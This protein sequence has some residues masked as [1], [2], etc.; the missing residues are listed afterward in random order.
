MFQQTN[1]GIC[2]KVKVI[3]KASRSELVGWEKDE[4][5]VRLAALPEK[6]EANAELIRYLAHLLKL[7][8]SNIQLVQGETSRHKRICITGMV[9]QEI[10]KK[11]QDYL[12]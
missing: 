8:K 6:G 11:V 5:K 3:P 1:Q 4:L 12:E 10:Q 2:F 9:L 7:A